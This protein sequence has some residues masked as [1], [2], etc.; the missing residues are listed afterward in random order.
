MSKTSLLW[1]KNLKL[2]IEHVALSKDHLLTLHEYGRCADLRVGVG[3]W[4]VLL[5]RWCCGWGDSAARHRNQTLT[6]GGVELGLGRGAVWGAGAKIS[7]AAAQHSHNT[8]QHYSIKHHN[9]TTLHHYTP[10]LST[11]LHHN[12]PQLYN[13]PP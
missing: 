9:T 8:P 10:Q 11:T 3:C 1:L 5:L 12:A 6:G 4:L 7:A 13:T 2:H